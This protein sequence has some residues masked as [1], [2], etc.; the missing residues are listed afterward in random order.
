MKTKLIISF[1]AISYQNL[2]K[3]NDEHK[4]HTFC[5]KWMATKVAA[6]VWDKEGKWYVVWI[7]GA[8][9]VFLWSKKSEAIIE[10]SCS[11]E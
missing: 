10:F 11:V 9:D 3:I 1:L 2:L 5:E 6:D 7:T 8:K 4:V